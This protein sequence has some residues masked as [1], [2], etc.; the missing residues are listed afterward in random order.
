MRP[1]PT[2]PLRSTD[3][4]ISVVSLAYL[5]VERTIQ[6]QN[7]SIRSTDITIIANKTNR[8]D[9]SQPDHQSWNIVIV[10][11][12]VASDEYRFILVKL[13]LSC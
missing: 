5:S 6:P 13:I 9:Y 7:N 8:F 12:V 3:I 4:T 2:Q 1:P 10:I 11:N